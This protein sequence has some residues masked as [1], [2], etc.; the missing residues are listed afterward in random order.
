MA[1]D[2]E[3]DNYWGLGN[4]QFDEGTISH[5]EREELLTRRRLRLAR[6]KNDELTKRSTRLL[7]ISQNE[8]AFDNSRLLGIPRNEPPTPVTAYDGALGTILNI[9]KAY[10]SEE[11]R[12]DLL[13]NI[14]EEIAD[15]TFRFLQTL[16]RVSH[17]QL[18]I[19]QPY[20]TPPNI[21]QY[22][23][24]LLTSFW[25][26]INSVFFMLDRLTFLTRLL[27][28]RNPYL[29]SEPL[30]NGANILDPDLKVS[31]AL[32]RAWIRL[33]H[34][35]SLNLGPRRMGERQLEMILEASLESLERE[36]RVAPPRP[37]S[38]SLRDTAFRWVYELERQL[39]RGV[40][41][42]ADALYTDENGVVREATD[43]D[44]FH[45]NITNIAKLNELS[46]N[47]SSLSPRQTNSR[48]LGVDWILWLDIFTT[49]ADLEHKLLEEHVEDV[50][51]S[52][53]VVHLDEWY[54]TGERLIS[55]LDYD[56]KDIYRSGV[57]NL[58]HIKPSLALIKQI[59]EINLHRRNNLLLRDWNKQRP[60]YQ[61]YS[62][63]D[64]SAGNEIW[65]QPIA[66]FYIWLEEL[67]RIREPGIDDDSPSNKHI[68]GQ[69]IFPIHPIA[70]IGFD[71]PH[72]QPGISPDNYPPQ[73][74]LQHYSDGCIICV[75]QFTHNETIAKPLYPRLSP[76]SL[77][78]LLLHQTVG[79]TPEVDDVWDVERVMG[80]RPSNFPNLPATYLEAGDP[81]WGR[82]V[83]EE[84][85]IASWEW[86]ARHGNELRV[87]H[88]EMVHARR[89]RR[90]LDEFR[91]KE[92]KEKGR[93]AESHVG[94]PGWGEAGG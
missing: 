45:A 44:V 7:D 86:N 28:R 80:G 25:S 57:R 54:S 29:P 10:F 60:W 65:R 58:P 53:R 13:A 31:Y 62:V 67:K 61:L 78:P 48:P 4:L 18:K 43:I 27:D 76:L 38:G 87:A 85:R 69:G 20:P 1:D 63:V 51:I 22:D 92:I 21:S 12:N 42:V 89:V 5:G 35:R 64:T 79:I 52:K 9:T 16:P 83:E 30:P 81:S 15:G 39:E 74:N 41:G 26:S 24:R 2:N 88:A 36:L 75:Q 56:Y 93:G 66:D 90:L 46:E 19:S 70:S 33:L 82:S 55:D 50:L 40:E 34:Y 77:F 37:R 73:P 47:V 8:V 23:Q 11:Y 59:S 14:R 72:N 84:M 32:R 94:N 71:P 49:N 91:R 3:V 68:M 17:L 6:Y